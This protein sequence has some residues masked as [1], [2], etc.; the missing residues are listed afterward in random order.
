MNSRR[1]AD[2]PFKQQRLNAWQPILT[3]TWVI[4]TFLIIGLIFIPI[5][6]SLL[7]Q[8]DAVVEYTKQYDGD[9]TDSALASCQITTTNSGYDTNTTCTVTF[10]VS[11]KMPKPVYVYYELSNFYQN[12]RKYVKS[13][14]FKQLRG[15]TVPSSDLSD[16]AP[17]DSI[18]KTVSG[19]SSKYTLNPCG[20]VANS[21]FNDVLN[22]T[23]SQTMDEYGIAWDSDVNEKF[24]NPIDFKSSTCTCSSVASGGCQNTAFCG[25]PG[26]GNGD[27]DCGENHEEHKDP[28]TGIC[29]AYEYPDESTTQYLYESYP[30]VVQPQEGVKNE[31]F[32]VWMRTAGLPKFRKLYGIIDEDLEVGDEVTFDVQPNFNVVGFSGTK[33]IV[34]STV[35]WFGGKNP[36]LGQSYI[37]VGAICVGAAAVFGVK[38]M[39]RP[40]KLGDTRYLVWK[41]A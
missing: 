16:C 12:H 18:T 32:I 7:S 24:D 1:P 26:S 39:V 17:L 25:T 11:K 2:T 10:T 20:L 22:V 9:G 31:H 23:S 36:F 3:P 33:S 21:L 37:V 38:H 13:L 8:S 19:T 29:Y 6:L 27:Y 34:L 40:R 4:G 35:S 41:E 30:M 5:G 15:E 28:T 14:S